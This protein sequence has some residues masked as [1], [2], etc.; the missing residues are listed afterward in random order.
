MAKYKASG[1]GRALI[2]VPS[3]CLP[4]GTDGDHRNMSLVRN[5]NTVPPRTA[6]HSTLQILIYDKF[7]LLRQDCLC[8]LVVRVSGYRYR[9]L[10]FDSRRYQIF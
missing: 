3:Q 2:E 7:T 10:G 5:M 4:A 6:N 9:G 8:G 1:S